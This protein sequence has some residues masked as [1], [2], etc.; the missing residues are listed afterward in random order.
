MLEHFQLTSDFLSLFFK[1]MNKGPSIQKMLLTL[2]QWQTALSCW[3]IAM[4]KG[5]IRPPF[6]SECLMPQ[7]TRFWYTHSELWIYSVAKQLINFA[8][9]YIVLLCSIDLIST[10]T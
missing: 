9:L 2:H 6:S 1:Y 7:V 4:K 5:M 10:C 8:C 3:L